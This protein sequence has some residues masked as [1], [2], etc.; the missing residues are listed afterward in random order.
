M[1]F[2]VKEQNHVKAH[3][4]SELIQSRKRFNFADALV[5]N[6]RYLEYLWLLVGLSISV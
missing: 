4:L 1:Y 2:A 3:L 5:K 6:A